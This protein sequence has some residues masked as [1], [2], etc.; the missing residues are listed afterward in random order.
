MIEMLWALY[1]IGR[2]FFKEKKKQAS[3]GETVLELVCSTGLRWV[4]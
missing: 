3:K 2:F 1:F 4:S